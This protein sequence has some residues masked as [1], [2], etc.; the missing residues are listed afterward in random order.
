MDLSLRLC[1]YVPSRTHVNSIYVPFR[2][3]VNPNC[4][5]RNN[6]PRLCHSVGYCRDDNNLCYVPCTESIDHNPF[7]VCIPGWDCPWFPDQ[8]AGHCRSEKYPSQR[9]Q[10]YR[11]SGRCCDAHF[12]GTSA[13]VQKSKDSHPPFAWVSPPARPPACLVAVR[14]A[15]AALAFPLSRTSVLPRWVAA[16][17]LPRHPGIRA[18]VSGRRETGNW[19]GNSLVPRHE[20]GAE[21]HPGT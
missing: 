9:F 12:G 18:T 2:T 21:L 5:P 1:R 3:R 13:C 7:G 11:T 10:I 6:S 16:R 14:S 4:H 20:K 19:P 8:M 15:T 17:S